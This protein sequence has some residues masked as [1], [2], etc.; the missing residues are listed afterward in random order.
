MSK[1]LY[2]SFKHHQVWLQKSDPEIRI[3]YVETSP[4]TSQPSKGTIL[5]IHG[6]PET[7]YQFR[8]VMKPL[9]SHG[10]RVI[11]PDYRGAGYSSHPDSGYTKD[12]L[13]S[14]LHSLMTT[15]E[16]KA[17]VHVVGHDIGGM[18]A[19]AYAA[20][21]PSDTA[22][23]IWGEC[24]LP[25]TSFYEKVKHTGA[26]WHFN[27]HA[28]S[29]IAETLVKGNE[30]AYTSHFYTRLAQNPAA[31][32]NEDIDFYAAQYSAPGAMRCAFATYRL[33]EEDAEM[34]RKWVKEGGK[35][36]VRNLVL[37]GEASLLGEEQMGMAGEVY[38][39]PKGEKVEGSGHWLAEE[40]PERFVEK[41]VEFIEAE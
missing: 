32:S 1:N 21:F 9:S 18:I 8:H 17:P 22:S 25:G 24:P 28:Q 26:M 40:N 7:S 39:E 38:Q 37:N 11:A 41:V 13:A 23:V 30:R 10:Y 27:F 6:F 12:I 34:N 19:H 5:L 29:D 33:F 14:D 15:L 16:I 35:G 3:H 20:Q 2:Q 36:K 4:P 31:F